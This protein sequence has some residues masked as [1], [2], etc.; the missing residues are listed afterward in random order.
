MLESD[1]Y[2]YLDS[3][4]IKYQVIEHR[5]VFT[6]DEIAEE[7]IEGFEYVAKNLFVRDDKKRH[8]YLIEVQK[9]KKVNM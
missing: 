2:D 4:N 5:A 9:D 1:I 3:Q 7:N 8:Y 6:I